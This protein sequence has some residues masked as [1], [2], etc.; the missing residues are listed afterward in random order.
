MKEADS[1]VAL[2][3]MTTKATQPANLD[4]IILNHTLF[5]NNLPRVFQRGVLEFTFM[6][7]ERHMGTVW[8]DF[9]ITPARQVCRSL[10]KGANSRPAPWNTVNTILI[11]SYV[12]YGWYRPCCITQEEE[13]VGQNPIEM[14]VTRDNKRLFCTGNRTC[15]EIAWLFKAIEE[16]LQNEREMGLVKSQF[17]STLHYLK[18]II[19]QW[20]YLYWLLHQLC[21]SGTKPNYL[22]KLVEYSVA[23]V[24]KLI[25]YDH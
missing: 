10:H 6:Y 8:F 22:S 12:A 25:Q 9:C 17:W 16:T 23:L 3:R 14:N 2:L 15:Q 21:A 11:V 7:S 5:I 18:K 24:V 19:L 4:K 1:K 20:D 13:E